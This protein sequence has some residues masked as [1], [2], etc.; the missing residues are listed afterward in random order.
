MKSKS[1][2]SVSSVLTGLLVLMAGL[3]SPLASA[4]QIYR[5]VG[6]DGRVTFSDHAPMTAS[7][8]TVNPAGAGGT[9]GSASSALPFELRQVAAKYPVTIYTGENCSPC[10]SARSMLTSRGI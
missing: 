4:Q 10:G 3:V 8:A 5:I 6:P 7:N 2:A 9:G 1:V